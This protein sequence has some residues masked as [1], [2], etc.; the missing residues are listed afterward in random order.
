MKRDEQNRL[1][2]EILETSEFRSNSL[3]RGLDVVRRS[4]RRRWA[5]RAGGMMLGLA[6]AILA[7]VFGGSAR[8]PGSESRPSPPPEIAH[9]APPAQESTGI[10]RITDEELFAL[11]PGRSVALIGPAGHQQFVFLDR[12]SRKKAGHGL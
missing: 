11:F 10:E 1:L 7:M 4:R 9:S 8:R 5:V 2:N 3:R 6:A 12:P